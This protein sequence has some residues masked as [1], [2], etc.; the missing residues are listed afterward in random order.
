LHKRENE[1][2]GGI[3][4]RPEGA[5]RTTVELA[6]I[7]GSMSILATTAQERTS[8]QRASGHKKRSKVEAAMCR[9]KKLQEG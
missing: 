3:F 6:G 5:R 7:G 8:W 1:G 2:G 9:H 4:G